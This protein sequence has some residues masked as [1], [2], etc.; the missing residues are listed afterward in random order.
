MTVQI[1]G[2]GCPKCKLLKAGTLEAVEELLF[3]VE[4][5]DVTDIET[6]MEM[7]VMMTPA[8]AI[9]GEVKSVGKVLRKEQIKDIIEREKKSGN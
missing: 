8:L 4:I 1:L 9:D 3:S 2:T 5:E 7:G 6:I